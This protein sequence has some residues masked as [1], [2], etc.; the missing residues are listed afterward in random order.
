MKPR[1]N[2]LSTV[3]QGKTSA[4]VLAS[5]PRPQP[6]SLKSSRVVDLAMFANV[7]LLLDAELSEELQHLGAE[8]PVLDD[9][10]N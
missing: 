1:S 10:V 4:R 9:A 5:E 2:V 8:L 7:N 3:K 6:S